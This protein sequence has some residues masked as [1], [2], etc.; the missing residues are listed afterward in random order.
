MKNKQ[1]FLFFLFFLLGLAFITQLG[2]LPVERNNENVNLNNS[3]EF[4]DKIKYEKYEEPELS[5]YWFDGVETFWFDEYNEAP[6]SWYIEEPSNTEALV[7]NN[8]GS[9]DGVLQLYDDNNGE[10]VA[11]YY[12]F[13]HTLLPFHV[14]LPVSYSHYYNISFYLRSTNTAKATYVGF[15]D[16]DDN[17]LFRVA[18]DLDNFYLYVPYD[19][20]NTVLRGVSD[21]NWYFVQMQILGCEIQSL[22]VNGV[23]ELSSSRT[24]ED[25]DGC[26]IE[27]IDYHTN[28][29]DYSYYS[30]FDSL[31]V[32]DWG[33]GM[34]GQVVYDSGYKTQ[35]LN[36]FANYL[37]NLNPLDSDKDFST[38]EYMIDEYPDKANNYRNWFES[39]IINHINLV[40]YRRLLR[41]TGTDDTHNKYKVIQLY[42]DDFNEDSFQDGYNQS[43]EMRVDT[44]DDSDNLINMLYF[45]LEFNE[46]Y[47]KITWD[48][49]YRESLA[50]PRWSEELTNPIFDFAD[51]LPEDVN[52]S[53]IQISCHFFLSSNETN[54]LLV[55]RTM[56]SFN[57]R[58]DLVFSYDKIIDLGYG[59]FY[60]TQDKLFVRYL[61]YF[62]PNNA[63][64]YIGNNWYSFNNLRGLRTLESNST[65]YFYNF[66]DVGYFKDNLEIYIPPVVPDIP[67][68]EE[69][70]DEP[71][72]PDEDDDTDYWTYE[73]FRIIESSSVMIS[74]SE[75]V[76]FYNDTVDIE[77][78][79][80]FEFITSE[81][82]TAKFY[83]NEETWD[84]D[85]FGDWTILDIELLDVD[86]RIDLNIVRNTIVAILNA[87]VL[88]FQFILFLLVAGF[89]YLIMFII[90]A[91]I[92]PFIWNFPIYWITILGI[93][94]L[95]YLYCLF[96]YVLGWLW[97]FLIWI[98][99]YIIVPLFEW[100]VNDALPLII[101]VLVIVLAFVLALVIWLMT[102]T[103][104]DFDDIYDQ[105]YEMISMV[106][107][108][109][110]D[111]IIV[112]I[113]NFT[114][115]LVGLLIY[116]VLIAFCFLKEI[117]TKS[118]GYPNRSLA[119]KE[120]R[121]AYTYP[122]EKGYELIQKVKEMFGRWT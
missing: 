30:Y 117:Y 35:I 16:T 17:L 45:N 53:S 11:C 43:I 42:F 100:F 89:N 103:N 85:D 26:E 121:E 64:D 118:K 32:Y 2:N 18:L 38:F 25:G 79:Y 111:T 107:D 92:V 27:Y 41:L 57:D 94:I 87:I 8:K 1:F 44:M 61:D 113:E 116:I 97:W 23:E 29:G 4:A 112:V 68:R 93:N 99:E 67:E 106:A 34:G 70:P 51:Y 73:S 24:Y 62:N 28:K 77:F 69:P 86:I 5:D 55:M 59:A 82:Y 102:M 101:E 58:V 80:E 31:N 115:L 13:E 76:D 48:C 19:S 20:D 81:S 47:G 83:Y 37:S 22:L 36:G 109:L 110:I 74:K 9:H 7:I 3:S 91:I 46:T 50:V 14:N 72:P 122:F 96:V 90:V 65:D 119:L 40:D 54:K 33:S 105:T 60:L 12:Y 120:S 108:F 71:D 95:F 15:Y 114:S 84:N 66:L 104:G 39:D 78:D 88:F 52:M 6:L 75:T 10:K 98:F 21:N 63:T 56:V 49:K